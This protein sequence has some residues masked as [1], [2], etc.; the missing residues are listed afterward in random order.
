MGK[1]N[2]TFHSFRESGKWYA[3][4]RGYL[5]PQTFEVFTARA[6]R[7]EILVSNGNKFP[8]LSGQGN[9]FTYVVI[10]DEDCPQGYPLLLNPVS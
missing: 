6:R 3:T 2:A 5:S 7:A 8:G 1:E 10:P 4:G 9:D